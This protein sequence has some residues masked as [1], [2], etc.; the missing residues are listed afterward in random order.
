MSRRLDGLEMLIGIWGIS[1]GNL[2]L[3]EDITDEQNRQT[4]LVLLFVDV[5][6][7]LQALEL[8]RRIVIPRSVSYVSL[9]VQSF[10]YRS[11]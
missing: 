3:H 5:E 1:T 11:M 6:I 2:R 10:T 8:G 4:H 9:A 7:L